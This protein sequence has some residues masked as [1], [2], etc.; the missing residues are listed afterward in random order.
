MNDRPTAIELLE[1]VRRFLGEEV[2][3]ALDGHLKYQARVAANVV[4]IVAREIES[5]ERHLAGEWERLGALLDDS[6]PPPRD[7]EALRA[8]IRERSEELVGRIRTGEADSG[9]WRDQVMAHLV[10]SVAD[11]L[12][13]AKPKPG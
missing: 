4:A 5:E 2:V 10:Q 7:R 11:K 8:A 6:T 13:V 1:A 9:P 12:E 3:N